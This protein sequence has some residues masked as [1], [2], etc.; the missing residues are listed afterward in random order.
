M[1]RLVRW[2][3]VFG[4]GLSTLVVSGCGSS[5]DTSPAST[6]P[7]ISGEMKTFL[8]KARSQL[9]NKQ[10][11]P[12][13]QTLTQAIQ[14]DPKCAEAYLQRGS[15][16]A[17]AGQAAQALADFGRAI[18]LAPNDAKLRHTRGFLLMTHRQVDAAIGDFSKAIELNPKYAPAFNNRGLAWLSKGDAKQALA[19][20]ESALALDSKYTE[21]LINRGFV[22]YQ[23]GQHK[24]AIADYDA[25]LKLN[26]DN[27]NALNNRGLANY[28]LKQFDKAVDD[29]TQAIA[30][31]RYNP[32]FYLQ[33][34]ACWSKLGRDEEAQQDAAQVAWLNKL[35]DLNLKLAREPRKP[36]GYVE[37]AEHYLTGNEPRVA[38]A[39]FETAMKLDPDNARSLSGRAG[40]WLTQKNFDKAIADCTAAIDKEPHY[41]AFSRRGEAYLANGDYD[42]ALADF[43][44]AKRLDAQVAKAYWLRAKALRAEGETAAAAKDL[45]RAYEID[46]NLRTA[47]T[48]SD[49]A[50][51]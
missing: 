42:A 22:K 12:A 24:P 47:R 48:K 14:H 27:V 10:W 40:V 35:G 6:A 17:D 41:E 30:R 19:D 51:D 4:L 2:T 45:E 34:H 23:S 7:A 32:K 11:Q 18:E 29:F 50:R 25:A 39:S 31:D 21:A 15:L 28:E 16:L 8:D 46:P 1:R 33:R 43:K 26:P 36:D 3:G 37:L 49:A 9:Q 5:N 13:L 44:R 38:L 20:F